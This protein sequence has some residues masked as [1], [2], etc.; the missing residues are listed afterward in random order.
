[1]EGCLEGVWEMCGRLLRGSMGRCESRVHLRLV[2]DIG[3]DQINALRHPRGD[4]PPENAEIALN[5]LLEKNVYLQ[6]I[7][8]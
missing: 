3:F 4:R 5:D 6:L 1:M 2:D 8:Q 7:H